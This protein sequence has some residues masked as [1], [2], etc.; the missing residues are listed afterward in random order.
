MRSSHPRFGSFINCLSLILASILLSVTAVAQTAGEQPS[1]TKVEATQSGAVSTPT[2]NP[3]VATDS[4]PETAKTLTDSKGAEAVTETA[5]VNTTPASPAPT[6]QPSTSA[7]TTTTAPV[8]AAPAPAP[9]ATCNRVINAD[10]VALA[11]PYMLNRMGASMPNALVYALRGDMGSTNTEVQLKPWKRARPIVLRAN[12]GDCL[13]IT[14]TNLINQTTPTSSTPPVSLH[15][16]GMQLADKGGQPADNISSDGSFVGVNDSS[17]VSPGASKVYKLLAQQEGT[18]LLYS[19]GDTNTKGEQLREGLFGA[20]NV[21]PAGAEWYRSQVSQEDLQLAIDRTKGNNGFTPAGQPILNYSALYPATYKDA[22]GDT[23]RACTPILKM[24]DVTYK[25]ASNGTCQKASND[26]K[27]YHTD[28][29]AIITGP[30]AG[31]FPGATNDAGIEDPPCNKAGTPGLK[32][33]PLFCKNPTL[34]DRKQPYREVTVIYH[35]VFQIAN[36]AFSIFQGGPSFQTTLAG[37]DAFAINY[38]TGGIGAEIYANRIGVGP[39]ANCVD[40]K[41]EEFFL[42]SWSVGD[43]AMVVDVPANFVPGFPPFD[44]PKKDPPPGPKATKAFY[45][46]DPS[47]VYHSYLNDHIKFRIL[48]GGTGVTHVH[49]QH[50]HQWLQ[51]PNSSE[52]NYL[53][54]QFISPGASYTLEMVYNGSGNLN[55]TVGDSIFHC[56]FYPHFAAGM[57]SMWRV[58]DVFEAGTELDKNGIPV[59]GSRALPDAEIAAGTAI[60]AIVPLPTMPMPLMPSPVFISDGSIVG[61]GG[62]KVAAGQIVYGTPAAPDPTGQNV[63]QNPGY[64]FFIPGVAGFRP[65]H[66][67][68]DFAPDTANPG[69]LLDGGLPRHVNVGGTVKN[70]LLF[71]ANITNWSKDYVTLNSVQLPEEGTHVEQVAIGYHGQRCRSTFLP[72]GSATNPFGPNNY[73]ECGAAAGQANFI[74]N[75]LPRKTAQNPSGAQSGSPFADPAVNKNGTPVGKARIYKAAAIQMDLTFDK[76][77][78]GLNVPMHYQQQ[79]LLTLWQDVTPTLSKARPAQPLFFRANSEEDFIEYW[80]TNLVPNY[81]EKDA[82][83]VRTPTDI[84]GQHIHQVKFDVT[85]SDGAANGFNYE[86][87]TFGPD[88]VREVLHAVNSPGGSWDRTSFCATCSTD[89]RDPQPPPAEICSGTPLP[90][91]CKAPPPAENCSGTG[92]PPPPQCKNGSWFGAQTTIQ[93]WYVDPFFNNDGKDNTIRT[94]FT[95]DH[96]GPSTHQQAGLYAGLLAEPKGSTWT[97]NDGTQTFGTRSDGGPTSWQ[98]R[99]ITGPGDV[100]S[101]REF[102]LEFQDFTLAYRG[103]TPVNPPGVPTLVSTG[104]QPPPGTQTVNYY[105]TPIPW[106]VHTGTPCD[107]SRAFDSTCQIT[108]FPANGDPETPLMRAYENDKVQVRV[109]IGA[110]TFSHFFTMAGLKWRFEPAWP[111]SGYRSSQGMGLSEHFEMLFNVPPSSI[112]KARPKCPDNM[113]PGDCVDYLYVPSEDNY[114]ITNGLWGLLRA[115]DPTKPFPQVKPLPSNPLGPG[116]TLGAFQACPQGQSPRKYNITAVSAQAALPGGQIVYNSRGI[117]TDPTSVIR[118]LGLMYVFSEDLDA[119]GKLKPNVPVEPLILR[120]NAGDCIEVTLTNKVDLTARPFTQLDPWPQPFFSMGTIS[121]SKYV[122]LHPQLLSYDAATDGGLNVGY[123]PKN[124][125]VANDGTSTITYKWYAGNIDRNPNGSLKYTPIE[126]GSLNLQPADPLM[127]HQW[128]LFG[129]MVIEP[130]GSKWTCDALDSNGKTI[131][132]PCEPTPGVPTTQNLKNYTRASA[133]VIPAAG[134]QFRE[135]V[136]MVNEDLILS[137][138]NRSAI[139]Y[140]TEPTYYRYGNPN[141][142]G[143]PALPNFSP[144]GD[145]SCAVSN[146]LVAG[147]PQTPIFTANAGTPV[148]FRLMHPQGSGTAQV[149]T[150]NGHV[151]QREPY[152]NGSAVIG[153]N[154]LSQWLGSHDSHGG[155]DHQD[156]VIDKAGGQFGVAGDYLY[157]VFVPNQNMFGSWGIFRVLDNGKQVGN[158]TTCTPLPSAPKPSAPLKDDLN[159]FIRQPI[160]TEKP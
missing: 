71:L 97:S 137:S 92:G 111:N 78:N 158:N 102:A 18:Y 126:F 98:A 54:S 127:Q 38:G 31:R 72:D 140:R 107:L 17:L 47:N 39:M 134:T 13:S 156:I 155:T 82:F 141:P 9:A 151:W 77:G 89:K 2:G 64:P 119:S 51:S 74:L 113:S 128:S 80:H 27:L 46:D 76:G 1:M 40:C 14:L 25:I 87:G 4:A 133:T 62:K 153:D 49:H 5:A 143:G 149:F 55:K 110:H 114:G 125:T 120:A 3:S 159:R 131:Q 85:S 86:D 34:P 10:V 132:V 52:S 8:P 145:N 21:Q 142:G 124:Q 152:T 66:P 69:K 94:I 108:G 59:K 20:V 53:D 19:E 41:F 70:D 146:A 139:N 96:F 33:D 138:G 104:G 117:P 84:L 57:W 16:Q 157:T 23:S 135:F 112:G 129:G 81:Y 43:P 7:T 30:N 11:Q 90:Q 42:S 15:V 121:A 160:A 118:S 48:H 61:P 22:S 79:R 93:R 63:T 123:N 154:Q 103:I 136:A 60:P 65:P 106:R 35:E 58:H 68:L 73:P 148:R 28:L 75:G 116:S 144:S 91:Q 95:H 109:L 44:P 122:G 88:E 105:N 115:Y 130:A 56:H 67:P 150:V 36:Q 29:T 50:A 12:Q 45:P 83:Q 26:L 24:V 101:Y 147:D 100:D 99:I 37:Q 6:P 32:F